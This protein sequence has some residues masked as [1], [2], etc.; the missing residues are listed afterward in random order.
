MKIFIS[1]AKE[2]R[3]IAERLYNDLKNAGANPWSEKDILPGENWK[4]A[5]SYEIRKSEYFIVVLSSKSLSARGLMQREMRMALDILD[6]FPSDMIF[7]IPVRVDDCEPMDEKLRSLKTADLFPSYENGLERILKT[8]KLEANLPKNQNF[9]IP[10]VYTRHI[11]DCCKYMDIDK[12]REKGRVIQVHLPEIFIP[13]YTDFPAWKR[14]KEDSEFLHSEQRNFDIEDLIAENEY[15]LI[16]GEAGSGKTTL[17]RHFAYMTLCEKNWKNFDGF[18]PILIFLKD[19]KDADFGKIPAG[20]A[21]AESILHHHLSLS[22]CGIDTEVFRCFCNAGKAVILL[23]GLDEIAPEL[24]DKVVRSFADFRNIHNRCKF[25]LS[26]RPH[27][28]SGAVV[29]RFGNRHVKI[30]SLNITQVEEFITRWFRY[31]YDAD[32]KIG[33]R[34]ANDMIGEIRSNPNIERLVD[35]PLLLSAICILYHDGKELPNQRAELYK[36]FVN[37]LLSRRFSDPE[38]VRYFLMALALEMHMNQTR[39]IDRLT[40]IRILETVYPM[41]ENEKKHQ[42]KKR[43]DLIFDAI[44]PN[45]GLLKIE[46]GEYN[47]RHLTFQEFF[48]AIGLVDKET[49]YAAAIR[50][51]WDDEWYREMILLYIGYLSIENRRWANRIIREILEKK[52]D[53]LFYRWR[54]AC[55]ALLDI[56][57]NTRD[58]QVVELANNRLLS[59]FDT[60]VEPKPRADAGEILGWLGDPRDLEEFVP[61]KGGIYELSTEIFEIQPFEMSKYLV[62]NQ[63]YAKFVRDGGYANKEFWT[64][65][66][67]KWLEDIGEKVPEY[68]HNKKWNCPN[69]PVVGVSWYEAAAFAKWLTITRNDGNIYRLPDENEWESAAAGFEK[70]MFAYGNEFDKNKCNTAILR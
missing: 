28:I 17:F 57:P 3:E 55:W 43:L 38:N 18:L 62:T 14:R 25:V 36:K 4:S 7:V 5:I 64:E 41:E 47:F 13:L 1:H 27:G 69:M 66:G 42:Y 26:G 61:V 52:D 8:L 30:L 50:D 67:L 51:F 48:A 29:E 70:R 24:R 2:D 37:N 19:I 58:P 56:H 6:E 23:D 20:K 15:L 12:L 10:E 46:G 63:W 44:E 65:E 21:L 49:D 34:T 53:K 59:I 22:D 32:S 60:D 35:N 31:V 40:A 45:S 54:L 16:E 68:W 33:E 9:C 39:G 11:S